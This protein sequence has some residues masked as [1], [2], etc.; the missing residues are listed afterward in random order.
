MIILSQINLH[1]LH[2]TTK[3]GARKYPIVSIKKE[4][5][6]PIFM[7]FLEIDHNNAGLLPLMISL[8]SGRIEVNLSTRLMLAVVPT[9]F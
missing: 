5:T 6:Y 9:T 3:N 7:L 2:L 1:L 8:I 4:H